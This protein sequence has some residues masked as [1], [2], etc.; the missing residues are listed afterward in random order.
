VS[1]DWKDIIAK[2]S[3]GRWYEIAEGTFVPSVTTMLKGGTP[4]DEWFYK[5]LITASE[6]DYDKYLKGK[7]EASRVGIRTHDIIEHLLTGKEYLFTDRDP[8]V[9]RAVTSFVTWWQTSGIKKKDI[10]EIEAF[11]YSTELKDGDLKY[12][13]AGRPDLITKMPDPKN[14]KKKIVAMIDWKTSKRPDDPSYG[15]QMSAYKNLWDSQNKEPIDKMYVVWCKKNFRGAMPGKTSRFL[16]EMPYDPKS[17]KCAEYLFDK[18]Y[19]KARE[20]KATP[21]FKSDLIKEFRIDL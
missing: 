7:S 3:N 14:P 6:G 20:T 19:S 10:I 13:Y 16:Y 8:E 2:T 18:F 11:L 17:V 12:R 1:K 9:Q 4:K 21:S 15:M 5:F